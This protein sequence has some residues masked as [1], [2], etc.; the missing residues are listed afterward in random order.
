[1]DV[2]DDVLLEPRVPSPS[3][4][5]TPAQ[6]EARDGIPIFCKLPKGG[7]KCAKYYIFDKNV[8]LRGTKGRVSST[9]CR[10]DQMA[11]PCD[12]RLLSVLTSPADKRLSCAVL[13]TRGFSRPYRSMIGRVQ[14][15]EKGGRCLGRIC[16]PQNHR[17]VLGILAMCQR[18]C[19]SAR[20]LLKTRSS[21][22]SVRGWNHKGVHA[23]SVCISACHLIYPGMMC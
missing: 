12:W 4:A 13:A 17:P 11:F 9:F 21:G 14:G 20:T 16:V 6:R 19:A 5:L 7:R 22:N 8:S 1:M 2:K 15:S 23:P 3:E 10:F 18:Q